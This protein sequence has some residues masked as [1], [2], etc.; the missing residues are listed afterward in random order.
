MESILNKLQKVEQLMDL[1]KH[2]QALAVLEDIPFDSGFQKTVWELRFLC[3]E[4]LGE[5]KKSK[6]IL[7]IALENYPNYAPFHVH[8]SS[9]YFQS[10]HRKKAI[11]AINRAIQLAPY[12]ADYKARAAIIFF[13]NNQPKM[14]KPLLDIAVEKDPNSLDVII[15]QAVYESTLKNTEAALSHIERGLEIDPNNIGLLSI[16]TKILTEDASTIKKAAA[17]AQHALTLDPGEES[18]RK[19]LLEVFRNK[20]RVL[21]FFVG[22]SFNRYRLEWTFWRVILM[23]VFW[24]GVILWGGVFILYLLVTWYGS[25]LF[26]SGVRLHPTY[27]VLLNNQDIQQSNVFLGIHGLLL[28]ALLS[29]NFYPV[30][31]D[32][33]FGGICLFLLVL[34]VGISY[35]EIRSKT[36]KMYFFIFCGLTAFLLFSLG[37]PP[38]P[39]GLFCLFFLLIYAFLF[40]LNIAFK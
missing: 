36:G 17:A 3:Y 14:G 38:T 40:T 1:G 27:K 20:N 4:A 22:N 13:S 11:K 21:R 10:N 32:L 18:V 39:T 8:L 31:Q 5:I 24:K 2:Q 33:Y 9:Y 15:A 29:S 12:N 26:N 30:D 28:L 25:V 34:L 37:L 16:R 23:I 6:K 7:D 19:D 35:F